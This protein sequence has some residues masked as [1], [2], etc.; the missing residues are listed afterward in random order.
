MKNQIIVGM[1]IF[2]IVFSSL[3]VWFG[4]RATTPFE[5]SLTAILLT[6][7]SIIFTWVVSHV[8]AKSTR[9]KEIN[10]LNKSHE[11]SLR[12]YALKAAEKV[13]NLSKELD[14][15]SNYLSQYIESED[16]DDLEVVL[17]VRDQRIEGAIHIVGMLRSV[18]DGALSDWEGVIGEE[19]SQKRDEE[20]A[21]FEER[22][23]RTQEILEKINRLIDRQNTADFDY[24]GDRERLSREFAE[25]RAG[26][27]AILSD[28]SAMYGRRL[29][30]YPSLSGLS[31]STA[32][33]CGACGEGIKIRRNRRGAIKMGG[34][35]CPKCD[36]RYLSRADDSG[37]PILEPRRNLSETIACPECNNII[38]VS[39]DNVPGGF[40]DHRC[41]D[42]DTA[43]RVSRTPSGVSI[44][45]QS[46]PRKLPI[47][48]AFLQQVQAALPEQPWPKGTHKEV[49]G[50]LGVTPTKVQRAIQ[51]LIRRGDASP[52]I[53]GVVIEPSAKE[54]SSQED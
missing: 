49:A 24:L 9:E 1:V 39:L 14:R 42:C 37:E 50:Q 30:R 53:D 6:L 5:I 19:L 31:K 20:E 3:V 52:Q 27:Q 35:R 33:S 29:P 32:V 41:H 34:V 12:I 4:L 22:E 18:N 2:S 8:Y 25:M 51:E 43:L 13:T 10:E 23:E 28:F 15:L 40:A 26:Y 16:E 17:R 54:D 21:E 44:K 36:A 45:V 11:K 46:Q 47:D 7:I 48:A 38:E